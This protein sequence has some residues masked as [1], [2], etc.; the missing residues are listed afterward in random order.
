MGFSLWGSARMIRKYVS[1]EG[2]EAHQALLQR[3]KVL[4]IAWH[5]TTLEVTASMMCLTGPSVAMMNTMKNPLMTW[6]FKRARSRFNYVDMVYR[7]QGLRP[8]LK[9]L[10]NI[11]QC[12]IIPDE[13]FG[14]R[15]A[16]T[17][18]LPFF[19]VQ[20]ATLVMPAK[21]AKSAGAK[22]VTC[23]T[24]LI[25][26]TGKYVCT[27]SPPLDLDNEA[28]DAVRMQVIND[29]LEALLKQAPEQYMWTFRWFS[30]RPGGEPSPYDVV[31]TK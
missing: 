11:G 7:D 21:L 24:R 29:S 13:D 3:E 23:G 25:A 2:F 4:L 16:N 20:R 8:L 5:Q 15:G 27:F 6:L 10:K 14:A 30:S 26:E 17:V 22:V 9:G 19:A 12:V 18:F 28:D 31:T 1:T